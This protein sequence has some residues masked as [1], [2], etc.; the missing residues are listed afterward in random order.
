MTNRCYADAFTDLPGRWKSRIASRCLGWF[1]SGSTLTFDA[2][3]LR[4]GPAAR[5]PD[6]AAWGRHRVNTGG[7]LPQIM[8]NTVRSGNRGNRSLI[9]Q[10]E[11]SLIGLAMIASLALVI[12]K[13]L[14][15]EI[16]GFITFLHK[17]GIM[18]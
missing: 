5:F 13:I 9:R 2:R 6:V 11:H 17:L 7:I 8:R 12:A 3:V 16:E 18:P 4:K 14:A 10:I 1:Q 15:T